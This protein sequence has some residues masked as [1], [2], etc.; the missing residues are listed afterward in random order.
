ML[1]D[2]QTNHSR[3]NIIIYLCDTYLQFNLYYITLYNRL[4][5]DYHRYADSSL[6]TN[7]YNP[8]SHAT[9]NNIISGISE[10][11]FRLYDEAYI[12]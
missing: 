4:L 3:T 2:L 10:H 11:L 12:Y 6:V 9:S 1:A 5:S 7:V 8:L